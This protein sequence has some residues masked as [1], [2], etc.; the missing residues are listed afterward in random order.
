M[1]VKGNILLTGYEAFT[2]L[3]VNLS[4]EACKRLEGNVYNGNTVVV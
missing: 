1:S 4:I 3:K 2:N